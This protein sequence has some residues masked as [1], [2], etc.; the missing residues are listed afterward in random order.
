MEPTMEPG[1]QQGARAVPYWEGQLIRHLDDLRTGSYE[2]AGT[3]AEREVVFRSAVELLSGTVLAALEAANHSLLDSH[4]TVMF[5]GVTGD[6]DGGVFASWELSWPAAAG[7]TGKAAAGP[8]AARAS[9]GYLPARLDTWP[10]ARRA[11]GKLAAAGDIRSRRPR[12]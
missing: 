11:A 2:G 4:G 3:R 8:G 5:T 6:G 9:A 12:V 7:V 1:S 10:P